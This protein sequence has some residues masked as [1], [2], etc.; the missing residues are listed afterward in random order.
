MD[1]YKGHSK[2]AQS[3]SPILRRSATPLPPPYPIPHPVSRMPPRRPQGARPHGIQGGPR[4]DCIGK[5]KYVDI[6]SLDELLEILNITAEEVFNAPNAANAANEA[7]AANA[8]GAVVACPMPMPMH[9]ADTPPIVEVID[10]T[11]E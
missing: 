11:I 8:T 9:I 6:V 7:N 1:V 3:H 5:Y 2:P 10:L 4:A